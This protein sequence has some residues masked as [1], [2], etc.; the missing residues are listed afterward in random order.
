MFARPDNTPTKHRARFL[1]AAMV[2]AT[3]AFVLP[4]QSEAGDGTGDQIRYRVTNEASLIIGRLH[5]YDGTG[6][7]ISVRKAD[8]TKGKTGVVK[9]DA[10]DLKPGTTKLE[11]R[12]IDVDDQAQ[13]WQ[14]CGQSTLHIK[15]DGDQITS[16]KLPDGTLVSD[17]LDATKDEIIRPRVKVS[18]NLFTQDCRYKSVKVY[19]R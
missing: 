8:I 18:G 1:T 14:K 17:E 2:L 4:S 3:A 15:Y 13:N 6:N 11:Y 19:D 12:V 16:V 9:F 5:I 10:S 7:L